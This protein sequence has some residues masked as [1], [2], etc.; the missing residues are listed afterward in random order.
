MKKIGITLL[1]LAIYSTSAWSQMGGGMMGRST[2]QLYPQSYSQEEHDKLDELIRISRGGQ[3]YDNWW[4]A[5][6][7]T[8]KP[9][10]DH[11]LWKEQSTNN[12]NGY[13]TYR[14]KECHGWDYRGK[15]GAYGKGSHHTG[16]KGV[17]E[18]AKKM[19]IKELENVNKRGAQ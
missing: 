16:F 1:I 18:A 13:D 6:I 14:C 7:D 5:T 8:D 15:N 11:P 2:Q 9:Q 10:K 19:S 12:R 3:L 17:Y 4:K